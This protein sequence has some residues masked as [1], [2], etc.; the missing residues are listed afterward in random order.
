MGITRLLI[1]ERCPEGLKT[2]CCLGLCEALCIVNLPV[3]CTGIEKKCSSRIGDY[4]DYFCLE[5]SALNSDT[6][7]KELDSQ[8]LLSLS[9]N[10]DCTACPADIT[11]LSSNTSSS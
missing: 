2:D 10:C 9:S 6:S 1:T 3:P 11:I 5:P 8:T 7:P 4:Y